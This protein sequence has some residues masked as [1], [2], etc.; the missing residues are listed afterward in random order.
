MKYTKYNNL[1]EAESW[2]IL[3]CVECG[4]CQYICPANI[5]LVHWLRVGKNTIMS[6]KRK[7]V[8]DEK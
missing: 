2:G 8:E 6:K 4:C 3:D 5:P 1:L 7:Q